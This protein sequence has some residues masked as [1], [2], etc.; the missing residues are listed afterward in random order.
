MRFFCFVTQK[1]VDTSCSHRLTSDPFRSDACAS[2]VMFMDLN[3]IPRSRKDL[4]GSKVQKNVHESG[5]MKCSFLFF[6]GKIT[7]FLLAKIRDNK[8]M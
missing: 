2:L 8:M 1:T 5:N 6:G 4:V 3:R 7:F